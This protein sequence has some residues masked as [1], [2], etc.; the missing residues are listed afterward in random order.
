MVGTSDPLVTDVASQ[1]KL[2]CFNKGNKGNKF[3]DTEHSY[4][5]GQAVPCFYDT[6]SFDAVF[7][8][9]HVSQAVRN[10]S[11]Y[12]AHCIKKGLRIL[13]NWQYLHNCT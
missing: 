6:P 4:L 2:S 1:G 13:K 10:D 11:S 8:E 12:R 9:A 7:T 5:T 3:N